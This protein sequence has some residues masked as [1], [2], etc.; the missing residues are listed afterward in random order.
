MANVETTGVLGNP[1]ARTYL[2]AAATMGLGLALVQGADDIHLA[3]AAAANAPAFAILE[4]S[5]VS[6]GEPISAIVLGEAVAV[7][8]AAVNAGQYLV[9]DSQGRLVPATGVSNQNIV[10]RAV[11]SGSSAG[12]YIV[13][14]VSPDSGI[15]QDVVTHYVASGAIPVLPGTAGLGS[16]G[17]LAMTLAQPTAAQDGT[18]IFVTAET[19]HAHTITTAASGINGSKHV[20]TFAAQGDGVVLEAINAV[21]NVRALI[22]AAALS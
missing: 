5:N 15:G 17:V 12:D 10:A 16:A 1:L 14:L 13:V 3:V 4:E 8:G 20:V 2:A 7:I 18:Q 22:G 9:T 21:W 19:T 11:S 6:I